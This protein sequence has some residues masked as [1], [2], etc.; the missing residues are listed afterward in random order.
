MVHGMRVSR[1]VVP[2]ALLSLLIGIAGSA[3]SV[4]ADASPYRGPNNA[5]TFTLPDGWQASLS[6]P[7]TVNVPDPVNGSTFV[8]GMQPANSM[9]LDD[10]F[11]QAQTLYTTDPSFQPDPAGPSDLMVGGQPAKTI[12]FKSDVVAPGVITAINDDT[13]YVMDFGTSTDKAS[14]SDPGLQTILTPWQFS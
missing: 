5:Y 11:Q 12:A 2:I 3:S 8:I 13:Q 1:Y 14:A 10:V 4:A 9:S 6:D 7:N